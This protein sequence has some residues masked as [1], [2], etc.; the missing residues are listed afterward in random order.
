[1][2]LTTST[3]LEALRQRLEDASFA[4]ES[5]DLSLLWSVVRDWARE[6]VD[7]VDA[8]RDGDL[9]LFSGALYDDPPGRWSR[10][11]RFVL[12]FTRQFAFEDVDDVQQE[13]QS[14]NVGVDDALHEDFRAITAMRF[15]GFGS[16]DQFY[17]R[18][19]PGAEEWITRVEA[20]DSYRVAL[21]HTAR[22]VSFSYGPI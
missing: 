18:G 10:G 9:L 1:M 5:P 6:H 17:G 22:A 20:S 14:V 2:A 16:A 11:C 7:D 8:D 3:A 19:G 4:V 13:R 21:G 15:P 12:G